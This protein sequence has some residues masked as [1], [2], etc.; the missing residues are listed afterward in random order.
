MTYPPLVRH[1]LAG[2]WPRPAEPASR[3]VLAGAAAAGL[4]GA[5]LLTSWV[6][7]GRAGVN[8]LLTVVAMAAATFPA[9]RHRVNRTSVAF[10]VASLSLVA[11]AV[12]RDAPWYV[13]LCLMLA[14]PL[15]SYT[16]TGGKTWIEL[17]GGG[18]TLVIAV[19]EM[20]PWAAEGS[21]DLVKAGRGRTWLVARTALIAI[22]LVTVFGLLLSSADAA[23]G[24]LLSSLVPKISPGTTIVRLIFFAAITCL[25]LAATY[26][27]TTRPRLKD[28]APSP[29]APSGPYAWAVPLAALNLLFVA[30]CA[31]Q[32]T[33]LLTS[34]KNRLL[35]STGLSYSEYARQGFFQLV[36]VTVLVIAV[37]ALAVRRAPRSAPV[38]VRVLLGLLC[39]LTLVIVA[40]ALRRLYLYEEASGWTRLRLWVHAFELWL[41]VVIV[42]IAAA[43]VRLRA[44][45]LP[46]AVAG[47]GAAGL[48][49][50]GLVDPDGFIASHNVDRQSQGR[51]IPL[52][53]LTVLSA[54][55]VPAL[56]RLPE[57]QRSCALENIAADLAEPESWTS[58][59]YARYRARQILAD[60][61]VLG[62]P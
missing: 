35:R 19:A 17:V 12:L 13:G 32:A 59:N 16:L 46:R 20:L 39:A 53:Y 3:T 22:G 29:G 49:L 44:A 4:V 7:D 61:P 31:V 38:L 10:G 58:F 6:M 52:G 54:D 51:S 9:S 24:D 30:F 28:R 43:G 5:F 56:D 40:V 55:A 36:V 21:A 57:P 14:L 48:L 47:T 27:A 33:V 60:R 34:D 42:L 37:L 15:T 23:F 50:L 25:T 62:C 41:G 18:G 11:M 1:T 2:R 45:W 26:L 8:L